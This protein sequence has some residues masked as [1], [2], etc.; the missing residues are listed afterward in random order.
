M[1][2]SREGQMNARIR[3][4]VLARVVP[5][6]FAGCCTTGGQSQAWEYKVL[7]VSTSHPAGDP[8]VE[9]NELAQQGWVLVSS[10]VVSRP[11]PNGDYLT[12]VFVL[13]RPR[14]QH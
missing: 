14:K 11:D 3:A 8:N 1:S 7:R 13:K 12:H 9:L 4:L 2:G 10:S 5:I 6:V